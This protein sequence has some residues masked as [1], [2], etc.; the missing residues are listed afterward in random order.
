M[1]ALDPEQLTGE[2][3]CDCYACGRSVAMLNDA[4]G[5]PCALAHE[6]IEGALGPNDETGCHAFDGIGDDSDAVIDYLTTC[7]EAAQRNQGN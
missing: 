1:S 7:R 4:Q 3:L 2:I 6:P 5:E